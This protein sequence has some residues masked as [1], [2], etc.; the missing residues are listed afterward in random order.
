MNNCS[1]SLKTAQDCIFCKIIAGLIPSQI[2]LKTDYALV[3]QDIAPQAPIHYLII[4][5]D[6]IQDV[7]S[8][9]VQDEHIIADMLLIPG[10]LAKMHEQAQSFKLI[11]NNGYAAGQRVFHLHFHFMAGRHFE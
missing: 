2:I 7:A 8:F 10:R 11:T 3:I 1:S 9:T 6:H 4:P 5:L